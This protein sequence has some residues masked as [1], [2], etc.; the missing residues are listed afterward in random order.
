MAKF[1]KL[2]N[3][4]YL[5][6]DQIITI[7]DHTAYTLGFDGELM[8]YSVELTD[9]DLQKILE[10][11]GS[12][13]N[14]QAPTLNKHAVELAIETLDEKERALEGASVLAF[15]REERADAQAEHKEVK[16]AKKSLEKYL[17][18]LN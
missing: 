9:S 15:D 17:E 5:N 6:V 10:A 14:N 11:T 8:T 12:D 16:N 1:V 3:E 4:T 2:E 18:A 7:E 13:E